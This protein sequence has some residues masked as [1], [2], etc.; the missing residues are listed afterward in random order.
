MWNDFKYRYKLNEKEL[1]NKNLYWD[2]NDYEY[3]LLENILILIA[4]Y[5]F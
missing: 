1:F 3:Q 2:N 5:K 4:E